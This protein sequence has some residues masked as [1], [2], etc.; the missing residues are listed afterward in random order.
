MQR[1]YLY[2]GSLFFVVVLCC[3]WMIFYFDD[4]SRYSSGKHAYEFNGQYEYDLADAY[5]SFEKA[6]GFL[7]AEDYLAKIE[8]EMY[9]FL[10]KYR[11]QGKFPFDQFSSY[12][13]I[14]IKTERYGDEVSLWVLEREA[15]VV[16]Q[17]E[18]FE[19]NMKQNPPYVGMNERYISKTS[20]GPPT[21]TE[22]NSFAYETRGTLSYH[23]IS[24][25]DHKVVYVSQG[26]V[27]KV[28][29]Y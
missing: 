12:T 5:S 6:N 14:L 19:N 15:D 20:W 29:D 24:D 27:F 8:E 13:R 18:Q 10:K 21:K 9:V 23:W 26:E 2:I 4:Y 22:V 28:S 3:G 17:K 16:K 1:K 7:D 11:E 25:A